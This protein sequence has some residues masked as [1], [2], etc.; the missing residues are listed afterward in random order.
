MLPR[1][2]NVGGFKLAIFAQLGSKS[3]GDSKD[4]DCLYPCNHEVANL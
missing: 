1:W 2:L 3:R 4:T